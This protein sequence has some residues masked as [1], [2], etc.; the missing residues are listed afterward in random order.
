MSILY[1]FVASFIVGILAFKHARWTGV[2][3]RRTNGALFLHAICTGI[4][5]IAVFLLTIAV[6]SLL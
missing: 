1:A 3:T 6:H 4:A 5:V 2:F